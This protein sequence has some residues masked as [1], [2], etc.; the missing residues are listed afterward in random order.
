MLHA[1]CGAPPGTGGLWVRVNGRVGA[2]APFESDAITVDAVVR[3]T[4]PAAAPAS[5]LALRLGGTKVAT[6]QVGALAA[7][8][9][10]ATRPGRPSESWLCSQ[11]PTAGATFSRR[12]S[13]GATGTR[14]CPTPSSGCR[15][16]YGGL[17]GRGC[18][19][20]GPAD[21]ISLT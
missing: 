10:M 2:S 11:P 3:N 16:P 13:R 17:H 8:A 12:R 20:L 9:R 15:P 14:A 18:M 5:A 1:G 4:G 19:C 21:D 7:D 6:A